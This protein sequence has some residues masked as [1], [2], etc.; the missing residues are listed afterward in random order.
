MIHISL[1]IFIKSKFKLFLVL[2][3]GQILITNN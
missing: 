3:L 2:Y 1:I